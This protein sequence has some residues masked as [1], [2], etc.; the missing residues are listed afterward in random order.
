[1]TV[2]ES[3]IL[4]VLKDKILDEIEKRKEALASGQGVEDFSAFKFSQGYVR[5]MTDVIKLA[6][7]LDADMNTE[8]G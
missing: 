1:M 8:G 3:R 6:D 2:Y 7:E 5:G 4:R